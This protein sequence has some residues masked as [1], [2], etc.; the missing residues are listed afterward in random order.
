M[1]DR[2]N[3]NAG[4]PVVRGWFV[5]VLVGVIAIAAGGITGRMLTTASGGTGPSDTVL[6]FFQAV[7]DNNAKAALAQLATPP[8]DTTFITD[9]ILRAAHERGAI[10]DISVPSTNSTVVPVSYTI[11]GEAVT[12][13][14]SVTA[15]GNGYKVSTSLNSG[16]I[17]LK[18][19]IRTGLPLTIAGTAVS[20]E[21]VILL[22]GSYPMTT[23][24]DKVVYGT[25]SLVVK[26]LADATTANDLKLQLSPT[27]LTAAQ[28]A[29]SAS[30][31]ACTA[32]KSFAPAG[33]PFKITVTNANAATVVWTTLSKP[34][35]DM[36][37]TLSATDLAR[38]T[39]EVP[40][41]L[42]LAYTDTA[43]RQQE[44]THTAVGTIDLLHDPVTVTWQA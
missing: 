33:C 1:S 16:G 26:R 32:Q 27:G 29:V 13:R 9:D 3:E 42:S 39:V 11:A 17:S 41:K 21:T 28:S 40:L 34:A 38:S 15:V 36:I 7:R 44:L 30:L 14:I 18:G 10:S 43:P 20:T 5:F 6:K 23:T 12:D 24:T 35:D 25:G 22:P 37:V 2:A 4:R 31:Q 8:S 19:K